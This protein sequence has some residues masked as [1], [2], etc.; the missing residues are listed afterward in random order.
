VIWR[1]GN[2]LLTAGMLAGWFVLALCGCAQGSRLPRRPTPR[3]D[4]IGIDALSRVLG[5]GDTVMSLDLTKSQIQRR[6]PDL[7]LTMRS[8]DHEMW[9]VPQSVARPMEFLVTFHWDS[10]S[11][12]RRIFSAAAKPSVISFEAIDI[13]QDSLASLLKRLH[14]V[15]TM[16]GRPSN[17]SRDTSAVN[18]ARGVPKDWAIWRR[19]GAEVSWAVGGLPQTPDDRSKGR[20]PSASLQIYSYRLSDTL[21]SSRYTN[22]VTRND[23]GCFQTG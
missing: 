13:S 10:G 16:L 2:A 15:I 6:V 1:T 20:W 12:F 5:I 22:T 14:P 9:N 21:Q 17:C 3:A 23:T 18:R 11:V 7:R 19:D 8:W 4:S